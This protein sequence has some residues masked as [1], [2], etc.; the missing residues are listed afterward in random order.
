MTAIRVGKLAAEGVWVTLK[1]LRDQWVLLVFLITASFWARDFYEQF[2]DLPSHVA[3]QDEL[4]VQLQA[5]IKRL[6]KRVVARVADRSPVL[7]FPGL[8]HGIDDGES[9]EPVTARLDP[10][11]WL[12]SDCRTSDLAAFMIDSH[13][14]WYSVETDLVRL[15]QLSGVQQL[16]FGVTVHPRMTAGRAQFLIQITQDCGSHLQVDSSPRLHFRV[17]ET[18]PESPA[19]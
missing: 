14:Q 4:I 15:P 19:N 9:G 17:L 3:A 6:D 5:E 18:G 7:A 8:R 11:Q 13:D 12:R 2:V 10:V 1:R 16:A